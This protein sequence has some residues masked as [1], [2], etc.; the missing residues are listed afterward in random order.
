VAIGHGRSSPQEPV[1]ERYELRRV[2][3]VQEAYRSALFE[4]MSEA[5]MLPFSLTNG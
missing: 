4:R 5:R 1:V 3:R 2:V